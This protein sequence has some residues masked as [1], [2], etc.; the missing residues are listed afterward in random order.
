[1]A[2]RERLLR[3]MA[4]GRF[5]SGE[6]LGG[7][8]GVS[9]AAVWKA[10]QGLESYGLQVQAVPG[11]GYRL[12][13]PLE[14]LERGRITERLGPQA[15]ALMAGL[16]IHP[17]LDSTNAALRRRAPELP[18]GYV[19]LAEYQ[20]AGRGRR[21]RDWVSPFACNLYLSLSWHFDGGAADLSGLSL[22]V[23]VAVLRA[24]RRSGVEGV[25]VK[26][27]NDLLWQE[28]KLAG[29]LLEVTGEGNGPWRVVTGVGLNVRMP[30]TAAEG[31][32]QPWID[33]ESARPGLARNR[34]AGDVLDEL[35][36]AH[37][38]YAR[39]GFGPFRDDWQAADCIAGRE[40]VLH[41]AAEALEGRARG[42]DESGAL[43]LETGD[44]MHRCVAGEVSL[45]LAG[46]HA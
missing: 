16:E 41:G 18:S 35:L 6:A 26:W 38:L 42:V 12:A 24:L 33:V 43:L 34:L 22:A 17:V 31:I 15:Q 23:A 11:R 37:A 27:P 3:R 7:E 25:G 10:L 32:G 46:A 28:R 5:H 1:M 40:V 45:R 36:R 39:A 21:G 2:N 14:L 30:E 20:E 4:D 44:R 13:E 8:L 29:V 9:R 19:C